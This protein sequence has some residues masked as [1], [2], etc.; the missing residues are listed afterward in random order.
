M[1]VNKK[2]VSAVVANVLIIL[3]VV[4]GVALI[5]AA[6]RP[7]IEEGSEGIQADCFT[8]QLEPLDCD[9]T[10][11]VLG[12][13]SV[14]TAT[15]CSE[16]ADCPSTETCNGYVAPTAD[17]TVK[18]NPGAG[19]L[20]GIK[21]RFENDNDETLLEDAPDIGALSEELATDS[22]TVDVTGLTGD[23]ESVNVAALVGPQ[24]RVCDIISTA[25]RCD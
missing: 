9:L 3:L 19:D 14:T 23:I 13:C 15:T 12:T 18:R 10:A 16:D 22:W 1:K 8:T 24:K 2:G 21:F 25:A 5:W 4:V 7:S 17:V 6:V 20:K 11:E